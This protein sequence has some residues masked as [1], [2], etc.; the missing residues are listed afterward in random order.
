MQNAFF[1]PAQELQTHQIPLGS[2]QPPFLS[3][4]QQ[5]C[6]LRQ[7][8][9][10]AIIYHTF[11]HMSSKIDKML[12]IYFQNLI[13]E[14]NCSDKLPL[15]SFPFRNFYK[16]IAKSKNSIKMQTLCH[17]FLHFDTVIINLFYFFHTHTLCL[18][19]F[20]SATGPGGIIPL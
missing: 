20:K 4:V 16:F 14:S 12:K 18:P 17:I 6:T 15:Y 9:Y 11:R 13:S 1:L 8:L 5:I 2:H 10:S 19:G 7:C 3:Q